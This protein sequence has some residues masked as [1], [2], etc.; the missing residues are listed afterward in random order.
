M[1][2]FQRQ[3]LLLDAGDLAVG[4]TIRSQCPACHGGLNNDAAFVVTR[5]AEGLVFICHRASCGFAGRMDMHGQAPAAASRKKPKTVKRIADAQKLPDGI[6]EWFWKKFHLPSSELIWQ[7]G[8]SWSPD[9]QRVLFPVRGIRGDFVGWW[10]RLYRELFTAEQWEEKK[11][12]PKVVAYYERPDE[13]TVNYPI[14]V[15][16]RNPVVLVEDYVSALKLWSVGVYAVA[17]GGT[18]VQDK[19]VIELAEQFDLVRVALDDDA[20]IT[21][22]NM[23][24][25]LAPFF[26]DV[27]AVP[28]PCDPKDMNDYQLQEFIQEVE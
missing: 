10:G 16:K 25:Q 7:Q 5:E 23:W 13:F 24:K 28:V 22:L 21:G 2:H 20:W 15:T 26:Y 4:D 6:C 1:D 3:Q 17:L 12:L 18:H 11:H 19:A 9:K 27:R 14:G 8:V